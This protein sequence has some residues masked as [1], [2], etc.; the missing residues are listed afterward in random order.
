MQILTTIRKSIG[1]HLLFI[2]FGFGLLGAYF[3]I[4]EDDFQRG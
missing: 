3:A 4:D 2:A 1:Y